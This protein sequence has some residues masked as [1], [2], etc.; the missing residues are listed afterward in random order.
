MPAEELD[1]SKFAAPI[2]SSAISSAMR[3]EAATITLQR[4]GMGFAILQDRTP[5]PANFADDKHRI[6]QQNSTS[7]CSS[8]SLFGSTAH[9]TAAASL[10]TGDNSMPRQLATDNQTFCPSSFPVGT[11]R[12]DKAPDIDIGGGCAISRATLASSLGTA[13]CTAAPSH[14]TGNSFSLPHGG[15]ATSLRVPSPKHRQEASCAWGDIGSVLSGVADDFGFVTNDFLTL[16]L[17]CDKP[18]DHPGILQSFDANDFEHLAA[19]LLVPSTRSWDS[20]RVSSALKTTSKGASPRFD[21]T[22]SCFQTGFISTSSQ[23]G[24]FNPLGHA[25]CVDWSV[26]STAVL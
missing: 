1:W 10:K 16:P 7:A 5:K 14:T 24:L 23:I 17:N 21:S 20:A 26:H 9:S 12:S 6:V 25:G 11:R 18:A 13:I 3:K 22:G 4:S 15:I 19:P 2:R 8:F